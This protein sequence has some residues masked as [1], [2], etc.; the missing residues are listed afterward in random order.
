MLGE[1]HL[2]LPSE[3][4]PLDE[5]RRREQVGWRQDALAEATRELRRAKRSRLLRWVVTLGLWRNWR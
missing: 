3:T 1:F 2:T 4:F 5:E